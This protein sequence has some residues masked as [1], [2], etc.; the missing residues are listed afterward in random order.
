M[1]GF[2][3]IKVKERYTDLLLIAKEPYSLSSKAGMQV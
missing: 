2:G 3:Y 1:W